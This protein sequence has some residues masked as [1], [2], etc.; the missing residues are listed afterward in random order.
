VRAHSASEDARNAL[1]TLALNRAR[2]RAPR[3]R[4]KR[5]ASAAIL[6]CARPARACDLTRPTFRVF[7]SRAR[8]ATVQLPPSIVPATVDPST[9]H[10]FYSMRIKWLL[11]IAVIA[12][13][14]GTGVAFS[15]NSPTPTATPTE[16]IKTISKREWN[17]M[18]G[19]WAKQTEKWASCNKQSDDQ[20]LTGRK[21]WSF[22]ASCMTS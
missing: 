3:G 17:R 11:A 1:V 14:V 21:S 13:L 7:W 5:A 19:Q 20:K 4:A 10:E 22:I 15:Q 2:R 6:S 8:S 9:R 12:G 18:K 16:K